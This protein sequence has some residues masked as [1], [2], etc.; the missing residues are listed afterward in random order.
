MPQGYHHLTQDIRCQIYTLLQTGTSLK[1]IAKK[2]KFHQS[3]IS[4][5]IRRNSGKRGY[6]YKQ[7]HQK[8]ESRR[9]NESTKVKKMVPKLVSTIKDMLKKKFSPEQISGR[10]KLEKKASISHES[11]YQFIWQDKKDG[12][13]LYKFLRR[14]GRKY[15]Q[16]G[17]S[18]AGRGCIPDRVDISK[19]PAIVEGNTQLGHFEADS[20]VGGKHCGALITIVERK[21]KLLLMRYVSSTKAEETAQAMIDLLTPIKRFVKTIT[22]DNGKEF[23]Q[24]KR[25]SKALKSRFFFAEPYKSWQRGLN[26]NTNGLIRKRFPKGTRFTKKMIPDIINSMHNI[27]SRPRKSLKYRTPY[28][29][30]FRL[31]RMDLGSS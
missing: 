19:R 30:F 21:T 23:S 29:E 3:T 24:H 10:L 5:E 2:L 22:S 4:R 26:E 27:N 7:A 9:R 31:T 13:S 11:I 16:R 12:G 18:L 25:V 15:H 1:E 6:R 28:E 17:S 8:A 20:V 14:A